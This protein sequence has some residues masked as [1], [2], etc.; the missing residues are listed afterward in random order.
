MRI[1]FYGARTA[2]LIALL[3]VMA[4]GHRVVAVV[5]EKKWKEDPVERVTRF[6]SLPV[7]KTE[8]L[9]A[10]ETIS[11]LNSWIIRWILPGTL[12][13][14]VLKGDLHTAFP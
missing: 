9:N 13:M 1:V 8:S 4:K 3:T 2:G 12:L 14:N 10:E 5:P 6:L 7:H 11:F